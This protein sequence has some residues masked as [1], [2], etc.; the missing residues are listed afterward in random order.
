MQVGEGILGSSEAESKAARHLHIEIHTYGQSISPDYSEVIFYPSGILRY[1]Q[2]AF[3]SIAPYHYDLAQFL[4]DPPNLDSGIPFTDIVTTANLSGPP[5]NKQA[6]IN[7]TE[8]LCNLTYH[9]QLI[10]IAPLQEINSHRGFSAYKQSGKPL[11][12]PYLIVQP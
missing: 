1:G 7:F 11:V 6:L 10:N 8:P 9:T 12:D 3:D 4:S 5:N 2:S